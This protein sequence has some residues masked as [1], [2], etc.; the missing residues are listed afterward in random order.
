MY[1]PPLLAPEN[2]LP[3][4]A[5]LQHKHTHLNQTTLH[6]PRSQTKIAHNSGSVKVSSPEPLC[7]SSN[8]PLRGALRSTHGALNDPHPGQNP[9]PPAPSSSYICQANGIT[10][11][12]A[13]TSKPNKNVIC[14]FAQKS[15]TQPTRNPAQKPSPAS[16]LGLGQ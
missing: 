8:P 3:R 2:P 7:H 6:W 5:S 4:K 1:T 9:T 10:V 12:I 15:S 13:T 11:A 14:R 16:G